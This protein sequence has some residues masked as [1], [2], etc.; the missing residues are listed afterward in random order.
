MFYFE[1]DELASQRIKSRL[2]SVNRLNLFSFIERDYLPGEHNQ[3][4]SLK[5][6]AKSALSRLGVKRE[7]KRIELLTNIRILGYVFNP[8]S[9]Y[10]CFAEAD[11]LL[12]CLCE[13]GNTFGEKKLF[14]V[15]AD[16]FGLLRD[17]QKKF[18]YVSPFTDLDQDFELNISVPQELMHIRIDTMDG[19]TAIVKA[20]LTGKQTALTDANLIK[21]LFRYSWATVGITALIHFHALLLWLKKVPF[22]KKEECSDKQLGILNPKRTRLAPHMVSAK[23]NDN[24]NID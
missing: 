10:F 3:P 12:C 23:V 6:R 11:E 14:L 5:E 8:V 9:F 4:S 22:H 21:L 17:R 1:L 2:I 16:S 15:E 24:G 20:S 7:I 13:V 18:F 19:D